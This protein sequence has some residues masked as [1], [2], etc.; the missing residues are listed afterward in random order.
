MLCRAE[1]LE[2]TLVAPVAADEDGRRLTGLL[3]GSG[4]HVVPLAC[5]GGTRRKTRV[6]CAGQS[7]L[8]LDDGGPGTHEGCRATGRSAAGQS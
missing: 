3:T 7:R 1:D 5:N 2:V 4:V 8:R 6:R